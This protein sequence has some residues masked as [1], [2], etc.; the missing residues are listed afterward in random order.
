MPDTKS[1]AR[2]RASQGC[3]E[4]QSQAA[5][6]SRPRGRQ[7]LRTGRM[8]HG[9][10][11]MANRDPAGR[12]RP[13]RPPDRRPGVFQGPCERPFDG[14][15]SHQRR[16]APQRHDP[17]LGRQERGP[18]ADDREPPDRGDART[19]QRAAARRHLVPAAHPEQSR[20]RSHDRGQAPGPDHGDR[21][22][23]PP[24]GPHG[25]RHH[26]RP[27]NSSRRCGRASG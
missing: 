4:G 9:R 7:A 21:P 20:R 19:R 18:A 1:Q 10:F 26:A 22:D 3:P 24:H 15:H 12:E 23:D 17:D 27:T 11:R 16:R 6:G 13:I 2:G 25:H 14:S 8:R 5:Q